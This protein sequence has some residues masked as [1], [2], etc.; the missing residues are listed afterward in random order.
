MDQSSSNQEEPIQ[1]RLY[2][3]LEQ[4]WIELFLDYEQALEIHR[5][6]TKAIAVYREQND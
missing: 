4:R 3:E 5:L 1:I 2:D 6:L